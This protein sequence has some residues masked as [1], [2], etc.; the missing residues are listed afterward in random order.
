[1]SGFKDGYDAFV[2]LNGA[3]FGAEHGASYVN[4]VNKSIDSLMTAL[5]KTAEDKKNIRIEHLKGFAA[6]GWH[7]GTFNIDA[8]LKGKA[9]QTI[10]T[11]KIGPVDIQLTDGTQAQ[12][13]YYKTGADSAKA[14]ASSHGTDSAYYSGQV[15]LIPA[16]QMKAAE[17]YLRDKIAVESVKRPELVQRY[18]ETLDNLRNRLESDGV[19]SIPLEHEKAK[20]LARA[21]R[22]DGLDP[23]DFGLTTE[24]LIEF[25]FIAQ[26]AFKAGLTAA[27]ISIALRVGPQ[28]CGMICRLIKDGEI[29][30][31]DF[32]NLGFATLSGGAEGFVRGTIAAAV[33]VS[34]KAGLLSTALKSANPSVIGAVVAITM[35]SIQNSFM[36]AFGKINPHEYANRSA[37]DLVVASCSIGLGVA[38]GALASAFFLPQLLYSVT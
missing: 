35:N 13:K 32:K 28:I 4:D 1:M 24:E 14:Q 21:M 2:R 30:T 27:L 9:I 38:G 18:Q 7:D 10:E 29:E 36:L 22:N 37:Q 11:N 23:A 31:E 20:E 25:D 5:K 3:N 34:C 12:L 33:T 26:Q 8:V 17:K 6:E 15:R 16:D 19:E